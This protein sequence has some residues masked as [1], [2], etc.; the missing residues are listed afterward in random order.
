MVA[1]APKLRPSALFAESSLLPDT[2]IFKFCTPVFSIA[3]LPFG[4]VILT[5]F[6]VRVFEA[7][8]YFNSPRTPSIVF[9]LLQFPEVTDTPAIFS[10]YPSA[11]VLEEANTNS[12]RSVAVIRPYILFI[13]VVCWIKHLYKVYSFV[14]NSRFQSDNKMFHPC[15]GFAVI[16]LDK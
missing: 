14:S 15:N 7:W 4:G 13:V 16:V 5:F 3:I 8:S 6:R 9:S 1:E 2:S 12:T 11:L 10:P